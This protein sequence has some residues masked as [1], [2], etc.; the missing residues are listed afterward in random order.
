MFLLVQLRNTWYNSRKVAI[1]QTVS[2]K[3]EA[4]DDMKKQNE[5][6][7]NRA[8]KTERTRQQIL[9]AGRRLFRKY[10]YNKVSVGA[11][12]KEAGISVGTFYYHFESKRALFS[13][14][15]AS[16]SAYFSDLPQIDYEADDCITCIGNYFSHYA[17]VLQSR[18]F[19]NI[20]NAFFPDHGNKTFLDPNRPMQ[21]ALLPILEGFQKSGQLQQA[22]STEELKEVFFICARGVVYDWILHDGNYDLTAKIAPIIRHLTAGYL[23]CAEKAGAD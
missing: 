4:V 3:V 23:A 13:E 14:I 12:I 10:G 5:A 15:T 2:I 22:F 7:M 18:P 21:Q 11:I 9:Q 19:E 1:M 20:A 17:E 8:Q 6:E 16:L